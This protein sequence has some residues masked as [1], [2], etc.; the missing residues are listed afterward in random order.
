MDAI[1]NNSVFKDWY[2]DSLVISVA[3]GR[4]IVGNGDRHVGG[5]NC[6]GYIFTLYYG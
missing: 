4:V 1:H 6:L 5:F 2:H 3:L